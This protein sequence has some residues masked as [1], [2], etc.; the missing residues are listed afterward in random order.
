MRTFAWTSLT[1]IIIIL[2]VRIYMTNFQSDTLYNFLNLN[3][4]ATKAVESC[5]EE[6]KFVQSG[7][8]AHFES[9]QEKLDTL[10]SGQNTNNIS[11]VVNTPTLQLPVVNQTTPSTLPAT[12]GGQNIITTTWGQ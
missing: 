6:M 4:P 11:P 3:N 2:W 12:T 10:L 1:R 7:Y 5:V 8:N 9:I